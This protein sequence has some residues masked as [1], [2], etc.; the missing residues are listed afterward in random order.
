MHVEQNRNC[1]LLILICGR[2]FFL[3][4]QSCYFVTQLVSVFT[5]PIV[6]F[7]PKQAPIQDHAPVKVWRARQHLLFQN[8]YIRG[9]DKVCQRTETTKIDPER[10]MEIQWLQALPEKSLYFRHLKYSKSLFFEENSAPALQK[11]KSNGKQGG[12]GLERQQE[13]KRREEE[14]AINGRYDAQ[15]PSGAIFLSV[16]S[17]PTSLLYPIQPLPSLPQFHFTSPPLH[18][19][20]SHG[21][22]S[23]PPAI[24][25][26]PESAASSIAPVPW[27]ETMLRYFT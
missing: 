27:G 16:S 12:R 18:F 23:E 13:R 9:P 11:V 10:W 20:P 7:W 21:L 22:N 19:H 4:W 14:K 1:T 26:A 8:G 17:S 5:G 2:V 15:R 6:Q 25:P 3:Q 24:R